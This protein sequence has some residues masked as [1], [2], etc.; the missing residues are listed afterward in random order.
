[1]TWRASAACLDSDT[2]FFVNSTSI[3][4][5]HHTRASEA[6]ALKLCG[7]CE[8]TTE[9]LDY[10][11]AVPEARDFGVWG[12]TTKGQRTKLRRQG[13]GHHALHSTGV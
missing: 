2:D 10:A 3:G 9:C 13:G 12:G 6:P 1:M 8:V 11:L 5:G 7:V 4:R